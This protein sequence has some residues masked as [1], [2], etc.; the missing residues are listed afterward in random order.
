MLPL[1]TMALIYSLALLILLGLA[2]TEAF[3]KR[4]SCWSALKLLPLV[5]TWTLPSQGSHFRGALLEALK[6]HITLAT[7][8][9]GS[10]QTHGGCPVE[11][12]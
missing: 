3:P 1:L 7:Q 2:C 8:M 12:A 4:P 11:V 6:P 5:L 9:E 10:A